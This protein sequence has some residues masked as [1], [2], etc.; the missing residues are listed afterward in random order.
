MIIEQNLRQLNFSTQGEKMKKIA[1]TLYATFL[2]IVSSTAVNAA[3]DT[4]NLT[5][6]IAQSVTISIGASTSVTMT[7]GTETSEN[8]TVAANVPFTIAVDSANDLLLTSGSDTVTY[9][10][11][12]KNAGGTALLSAEGTSSTQNEVAATWTF[13]VTPSGID[14]STDAG[15]YT[16]TVTITVS[17]V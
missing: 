16:D 9:A 17:A 8:L 3:S 4:V 10:F 14:G 5:G 11:T 2:T 12:L 13:N 7:N 1:T 15:T 6:T